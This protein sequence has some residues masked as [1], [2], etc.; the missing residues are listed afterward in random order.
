MNRLRLPLLAVAAVLAALG[1]LSAR[2][3]GQ[4]D[5]A[6][7]MLAKELTGL[8]QGKKLD[9]VAARM[10]GETFVAAMLIP[11][12]ELLVVAAK[13]PAPALINEKIL[14]R[15]YRDAYM[16]LSTASV[17][18]SKLLV[19]DLKADGLHASR[20]GRDTFDIVTR[21]TGTPTH[22]DGEWKKQNM[23]QDAYM[24]AFQDAETAY[25]A[26]LRALVAELKKTS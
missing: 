10:D 12:S 26:M 17:A 2:S 9:V 5:G 15:K 16:D 11:D 22:F 6:T 4:A 24:K 7:P 14:N 3:G 1:S 20:Q 13:Y 8:L 18:E 19:E 21:G 23:S 25:Q